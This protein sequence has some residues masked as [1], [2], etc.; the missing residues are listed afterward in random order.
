[1][2]LSREKALQQ[3]SFFQST[4]PFL[5][6][7]SKCFKLK[8]YE[9]FQKVLLFSQSLFFRQPIIILDGAQLKKLVLA[10][11]VYQTETYII[12]KDRRSNLWEQT[13]QTLNAISNRISVCVPKK[14][15][16]ETILY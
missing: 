7:R 1:M 8:I 15:K 16:S 11:S 4:S 13:G 3:V 2:Q 10:V 12:I 14:K 6:S 9:L 5:R